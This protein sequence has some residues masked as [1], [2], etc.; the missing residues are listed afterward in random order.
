MLAGLLRC[1]L[2]FQRLCSRLTALWRYIN[3]VLLLLLLFTRLFFMSLL[4]Q[5]NDDNDE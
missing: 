2:I 4:E 3:F 1:F 5:I